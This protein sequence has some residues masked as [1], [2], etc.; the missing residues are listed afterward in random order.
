MD[1]VMNQENSENSFDTYDQFFGAEVCIPDERGRII[2][3]RV[4]KRVKYNRGNPRGIEHP[5]LFAD[6]LLYEVSFPNVWTEELTANTIAENMLY[7]VDLEG[8]H[9]Q[10]LTDIIDHSVNCS[11]F[12]RSNGCIRIHDENLHAK[13]KTRGW[14][15]KVEWKYG[16]LSWIS[17]NDIKALNHVK[18]AEYAVVNN[19]EDEPAFRLWVKY[20][21]RKSDQIISKFKAKYWRTTHKI[22][23]QVTKTVDYS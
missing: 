11:A 5:T 4:T 23:I 8:H 14:E 3:A 17:L 20:V 18:L 22:G 9:Y 1:D 16:T 12:K 19:I 7:Q 10:V 21:L 6:H 13:K 2:M 15:L